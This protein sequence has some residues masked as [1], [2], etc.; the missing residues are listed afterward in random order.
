MN[1][2]AVA[3]Y[4]RAELPGPWRMA[5]CREHASVLEAHRFASFTP[6]SGRLAVSCAVCDRPELLAEIERCTCEHDAARCP[7]HQN[8]GCGG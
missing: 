5:V 8:V 1:T 7:S 4:A 2:S 3:W 6:P